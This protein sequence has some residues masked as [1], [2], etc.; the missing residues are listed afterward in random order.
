MSERVPAHWLP[1]N[2]RTGLPRL[3]VII[4]TEARSRREAGAN[5][6]T[7][8]LAVAAS[9][10]RAKSGRP[11]QASDPVVYGRAADLWA[12]VSDAALATGR[13]VVVAHN[14]G[15]DLRIARAFTELPALGWELTNLGLDPGRTWAWWRRGRQSLTMVDSA[16]WF[17]GRLA[18][19]AADVG[20]TKPELPGPRATRDRWEA[21]CVADVRA[22]AEAWRRVLVFVEDGDHGNWRPTGAGQGWQS[23]RHRHLTHRV[24]CHDRAPA[25]RAERESMYAGR[26]EAW[27]WGELAGGP[28]V[29]WDQTSAYAHV[30]R[31]CDVPTVLRGHLTGKSAQRALEAPEG[32]RILA[33][34]EIATEVP[35]A[36][37][38]AEGR[39]LWPVGRF[40]S[41]LWDTEAEMVAAYGGKVRALE[42]WSY[43]AGPALRQWATWVLDTL[44]LP[45]DAL[46][47]VA[48]R[49]VKGWSRAVI[50]RFASQHSE[51]EDQGEAL[52]GDGVLTYV[53]RHG[54]R[55]LGRQLTRGGRSYLETARVDAPDSA[56]QV[57]SF[58]MAECRV[59][60]WHLMVNAGLDNV[61]Y[62]DTDGLLVTTDGADRLAGV[63]W[64]GLREK[65]RWGRVT[66]WGP[67][68][69]LLDGQLRASG[70]PGSARRAA[71]ER[72]DGVVWRGLGQAMALGELDRVVIT[73]RSWELTSLDRRRVHRPRGTTAAIR[74]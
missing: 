36:P 38:R 21:R 47:P 3:H 58:V 29:E 59:R 31:D 46:D 13:T 24:L 15:Y 53:V 69:Y 7:F 22:L 62:V 68:R 74:L 28:F 65:S 48:R 33:R 60:L 11:W 10:H 37:H 41:W 40:E 9:L 30:A 70:V 43:D 49:V 71:P 25:R 63:G 45:D 1:R 6:Q 18:D 23:Y 32:S 17:P 4:D 66:V 51:W 54:E 64:P 19:V 42:A 2:E 8:R 34:C 55:G 35:C 72:W 52:H 20:V 50:G 16:S 39:V 73:D 57:T 61:A 5:V 44:A 27:R 12:D 56:P 26:C 14:L 67:K